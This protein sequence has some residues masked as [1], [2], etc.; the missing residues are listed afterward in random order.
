MSDWMDLMRMAGGLAGGGGGFVRD[1]KCFSMSFLNHTRALE[2]REQG[3][4][5]IMPPS[6]LHKLAQ[7]RI[8]YPML[9]RITNT[10]NNKH[11][12]CGVLEFIA[13]EGRCYIPYWMMENLGIAE[14]SLINIA[15]VSL[16][17]GTSV[18]F[19]PRSSEFL[20]IS[21]PRAVLE[22]TLRNFSA[23]TEGETIRI[24]FNNKTY[25]LDVIEVGASQPAPARGI[26]IIETD[27]VVDFAPPPDMAQPPPQSSSSS[28][29]QNG[30]EEDPDPLSSSS[31]EDDPDPPLIDVARRTRKGRNKSLAHATIPAAYA[32]QGFTLRGKTVGTPLEQLQEKQR[33]EA[34]RIER[35]R[36]ERQKRLEEM[37]QQSSPADAQQQQQAQEDKDHPSFRPFE[38]QGRSLR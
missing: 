35:E 31:E 26:S 24:V 7:L 5:I 9:F 6:A 38:G 37:R 27:V 30:G 20:K 4:K 1:F 25:E 21:N 18:K 16:P 33:I 8:S 2:D 11:I 14:G 28:S 12:H 17:K 3:D 10:T 13:E 36:V 23:L 19:R 29:A 34:E 22:R 32:G 15:N